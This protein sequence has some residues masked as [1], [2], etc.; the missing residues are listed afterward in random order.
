MAQHFLSMRES[1]G[2]IPSP[3]RRTPLKSVYD[4][5]LHLCLLATHGQA[6]KEVTPFTKALATLPTLQFPSAG[7]GS[8]SE[9]GGL[10][11]CLR[12]ASHTVSHEPVAPNFSPTSLSS[13]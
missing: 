13:F 1:L 10:A 12:A 7:P 2:S 11:L 8:A 5:T 3:A 6:G 4:S 9:G